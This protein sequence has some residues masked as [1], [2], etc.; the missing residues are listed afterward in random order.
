[1]VRREAV[2]LGTGYG[3]IGFAAAMLAVDVTVGSLAALSAS[4]ATAVVAG[5]VFAWTV[6]PARADGG[7]GE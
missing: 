1:M 5:G 7:E 2:W 3:L 4:V 6:W